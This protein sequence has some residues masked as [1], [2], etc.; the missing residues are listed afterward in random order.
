MTMADPL[1][2][3]IDTSQVDR[4][5]AKFPMSGPRI[6]E[7]ELRIGLDD[8]L[9]YTAAQVVERVPVNTGVLRESIYDE[10]TGLRVSISGIDLEGVV[11]SSDYEPKVNAVEF[12]R[13]PGKMPPVEAIALWVRRKGLAGTYKVAASKI[14]RHARTGKREQ[15]RKEDWSLAWAIAKKIKRVGTK[16]AFMFT[17]AFEASQTYIV[18]V[19][20]AAVDRILN[21][22]SKE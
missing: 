22:W 18:K 20:D 1:S 15:Q 14:G 11:S 17:K 21:A 19:M 4:F 9:G 8:A 13:K 7:R 12:G 16:G 5:V 2:I 10:I 3:E 6:A